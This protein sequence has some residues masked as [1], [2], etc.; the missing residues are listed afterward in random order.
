LA[1]IDIGILALNAGVV[2]PGT[3]DQLS[4]AEFEAHYTVNCLHVVYMTKALL[5]K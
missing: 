2:T 3:V 1:N 4:D 5:Q